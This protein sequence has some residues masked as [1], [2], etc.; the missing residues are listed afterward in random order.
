MPITPNFL[1]V[2]Q[3]Y[4][5]DGSIVWQQCTRK[6]IC[7]SVM[8]IASAP[9]LPTASL[10][11]DVLSVSLFQLIKIL[12]LRCVS[13]RAGNGQWSW[14]SASNGSIT[15]VTST[16]WSSVLRMSSFLFKLPNSLLWITTAYTSHIPLLLSFQII[17]HTQ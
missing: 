1:F 7:R 10:P 15:C 5:L 2:V 8:S 3:D 4:S 14:P 12:S 17:F 11:N 9:I 13:Q 6:S 16:E